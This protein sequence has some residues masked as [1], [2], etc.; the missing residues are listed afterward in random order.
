MNISRR[1]FLVGSAAA[2][3]VIGGA[4]IVTPML[5][6]EGR[7]VPGHPR[8]GFV[9][10]EKGAL[11]Q[12]A[13]VVIIGG[14]INGIM[15]AIRMVERGLSVVVVEKGN[16]AGEQSSRA[17][18]QVIT[19]KMPDATFQLHH[20]GK[21]LWRE[22]NQKVGV[23]T[24][25]RTQGRVEVPLDEADISAVQQWIKD[26]QE[27]AG[28][29]VPL[30]TRFIEGSELKNK[31]LHATT[32]WK[33]GAFEEDSGSLDSE[34]T[35]F[36]MADYAKRI[37]VKFYTNCAA[38]GIETAAGKVSDVVTE[39]GAIRTSMVV[40]AGG[41]WTRKFMGNLDIDIPTLPAYQSQQIISAAPGA[42]SGNVALPGNIY[43]RQQ[44]N[45]TYATSPRIITAPV[46]KESFTYGYKYLGLLSEPDFP[47]HIALNEQLIHS[48]TEPTHWK[49]N[50][51]SPFETQRDMTAL[52]DIQDLDDSL[53]KLAEEFPAFKAAKVIDRWSGAM[54]IAP[55]EVPII[56]T[57]K[58]LPGLVL[59]TAT[60]WG[61]TESPVSSLLT[62]SL[63]LNEKPIIDVEPF[64]L[65]RF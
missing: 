54:A 20:L 55:D 34:I 35:S 29:G 23:D 60:G 26:K 28:F 38:R 59:N 12:H 48:L 21:K 16:I 24:S 44:S 30:K 46:V 32:D 17:Y 25:Y 64:S 6:R 52:P 61:M 7:F 13:D 40:V 42:P 57:I 19:Y 47:V 1:K 4:S 36:V 2:V 56:S 37:G 27:K 22:M 9:E 65:N 41:A 63:L 3:A 33:L 51:I 45:G 14:G 39:K 15:T 58:Q 31:L 50:E 10:G 8:W 53:I 5:R 18:G 62:T 43:F 49:L 11:P